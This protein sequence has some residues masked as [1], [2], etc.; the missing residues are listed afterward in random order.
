MIETKKYEKGTLGW[1]REQAKKDGFDNIKSWQI[2][3][4]CRKIKNIEQVEKTFGDKINDENISDFYRFWSK[5]DIK[6]NKEEC[7]NWTAYIKPEGYGQLHIEGGTIY[8]HRMAYVLTKGTISDGLE[9]Q[10]LCNNARCCNPNHLEIGDQHK[11][12]EYMV[13]CGRQAKGENIS[14][15]KM[16]ED[17]V[18]EIHKLYKE[19]RRLHPLYKKWQITWPIAKKF[20]IIKEQVDNIISGR[21]WHHIYLEEY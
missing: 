21:Q 1:L 15:S 2:W 8:A 19:Q 3:K 14:Q 4:T 12:V 5:V 20:G 13:K 18:R 10:H 16:T 11:N 9:V 7:W 17:Q 6:D